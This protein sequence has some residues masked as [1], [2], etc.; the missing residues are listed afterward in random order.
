[1][2]LSKE[3]VKELFEQRTEEYLLNYNTTLQELKERT[4]KLFD[5]K[6]NPIILEKYLELIYGLNS[7]ILEILEEKN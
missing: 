6:N 1:M 3:E 7:D 4:L 5:E 2:K